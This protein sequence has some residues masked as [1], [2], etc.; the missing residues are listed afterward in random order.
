MENTQQET[1]AADVR[2]VDIED[3]RNV[4]GGRDVGECVCTP[5]GCT[6]TCMC[7]W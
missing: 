2:L 6:P 5:E 4:L 3:V 1:E 7:P